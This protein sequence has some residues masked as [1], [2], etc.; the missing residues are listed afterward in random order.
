MRVLVALP[1]SHPRIN[2]LDAAFSGAVPLSGTNGSIIRM[3]AQMARAGHQV[4]VSGASPLKCESGLVTTIQ[5]CDVE[6]AEFDRII[7]HQTH[8]NGGVFSYGSEALPKVI[9]WL[10]NQMPYKEAAAFLQR[11]RYLVCLSHYH[12][13]LFRAARFWKSKVRIIPNT[14][15]PCFDKRDLGNPECEANRLI[16]VGAITPNK[17]FREM[18]GIWTAVSNTGIK[19]SLC[20]AGGIALHSH[21]VSMG[22]L[23]I[24]EASFEHEEIIPWI[25][26]LPVQYQPTF[27]G[28]LTPVQLKVEISKS[29]AGIVN[30]AMNH[31]ETF[32][33]SA[34]EIQA[35]GKSVFSVSAGALDEVV[36]QGRYKV[37][38]SSG[39]PLKLAQRILRA[40]LNK[41]QIRLNGE[42]ARLF[43]RNY[44]DE[45]KVSRFWSLLLSDELHP[46]RISL[47]SLRFTNVMFDILRIT[48]LGDFANRMANTLR[49]YRRTQ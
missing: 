15:D 19:L 12:A 6:C 2:S 4:T 26:Q 29:W 46:P 25:S 1:Q 30:P 31:P 48:G 36:Y 28:N 49:R 27:S 43:I 11:G 14:Y 47:Q 9:L 3:A 5:H 35:C 22:P 41:E 38:E 8:W 23:G 42:E 37:L 21:N 17:G 44:C 10:Q 13:N 32:C 24:A 39:N 40:S 33:V 45:G 34:A 18:M 7:A 20:I 16:F